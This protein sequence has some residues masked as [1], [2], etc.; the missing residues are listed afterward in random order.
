[1]HAQRYPQHSSW[2]VGTQSIL[3]SC[4]ADAPKRRGRWQIIVLG[5]TRKRWIHRGTRNQYIAMP[6]KHSILRACTVL[7]LYPE[8]TDRKARKSSHSAL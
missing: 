2:T 5:R 1:M 3:F 6:L 4:L 8:P 7:S